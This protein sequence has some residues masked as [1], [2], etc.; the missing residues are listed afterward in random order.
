VNELHV[1]TRPRDRLERLLVLDRVIR[2][3]LPIL[4]LAEEGAPAAEPGLKARR[5]GL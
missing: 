1:F 3:C 4:N 2:R 5:A